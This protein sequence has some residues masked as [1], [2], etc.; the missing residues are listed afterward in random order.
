MHR[1]K[2]R[3]AGPETAAPAVTRAGAA[4][5]DLTPRAPVF[6][7]GYPHVPRTSTGVHDP[8]ECAALYLRGHRG[9]A[10]FLAN[11]LIHV[12]RDFAAAVRERI[13]AATGV[14]ADAILLAATHT[15]SGPVMSDSLGNS[16]DPVVPRADPAYLAWVADQMVHAGCAA[17]AAAEPAEIGLATTRAEGVGTNRHD[18]AGP[19]DPEVPVLVVRSRASGQ[20]LACLIVYGMHPTVLHE[21]S[22]LVSADFPG[23]TRRA[24]RGRA[25]PASCPVL[26]LQGAAGDQSPR[27][28]TRANTFAEAARLGENLARN[29]A[30]AIGRVAFA[31]LE[32]VIA[33]RIRIDVEPRRFPAVAAAQEAVRQARARYDALRAAGAPRQQVRTAEC[34]VFGAEKTAVLAQTVADGRFEAAVRQ[35]SPAEIQLIRIGPWRFV[36]WPGEFFVEHSLALKAAAPPGTFVVTLANGELQGYLATPAAVARGS[37]EATNAVFAVENGPRFVARSLELIAAA[38]G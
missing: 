16:A 8:L 21:D 18:P 32:A 35:A 37:Y 25:L 33:R 31:P 23:F 29:V 10:L 27:H 38:G 9:A 4:V 17:V 3:A 6:L 22:T 28:L 7:F 13:A 15:H 5:A 19:A 26:Y 34:D 36:A 11:D 24:L 1:N 30:E 20:V 14:P 2:H 12:G